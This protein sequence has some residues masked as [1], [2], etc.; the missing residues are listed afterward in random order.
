VAQAILP[1]QQV[2][3]SFGMSA[4]ARF[5]AKDAEGKRGQVPVP[6]KKKREGI[7]RSARPSRV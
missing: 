4:Q 2:A 7:G 1:V 3:R 5:S 6:Q